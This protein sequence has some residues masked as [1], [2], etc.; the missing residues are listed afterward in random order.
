MSS[1]SCHLWTW[2][3]TPLNLVDLGGWHTSPLGFI[4]L[5]VQV[6][7]ITGYDEDIVFLIVP[8]KSKFSR[9]VPLVIGTCMLRRII[10][11]VQEIKLDRL[12][13]LWAMAQFSQLLSRKSF[14]VTVSNKGGDAPKGEEA[15]ASAAP[16]EEEVYEP[17]IMREN[18]HL[19]PFQM[20][21]SKERSN[22][23]WGRLL[24]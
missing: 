6:K 11:V 5:H 17:I 12:S 14:T 19:S 3:T 9:H 15:G 4:I 13:V 8:D 16:V 24:M 21:S 7:E 10:N 20:K 22:L 23:C 2:W 18:V 1:P